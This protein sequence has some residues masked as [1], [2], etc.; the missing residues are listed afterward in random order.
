DAPGAPRVAVVS[1]RYWQRELGSARDPVGRELR[2]RGNTYTIVGVAAARFTGMVPVL[3][4][5]LWIPAANAQDVEPIGIHD[6]VPS[7]TG[8]TRLTKRGDRWMFLR[9]RLKP[10]KTADEARANLELV[11]S[12]LASE[13]P[14]TNGNRKISVPA[15]NDVHFHPSA[16]AT[17]FAVTGGVVVVVG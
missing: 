17:L 5:E 4:P 1:H 13:Y 15:T 2:I 11:M 6:S 14:V 16:D 7:P 12:R 8:T 3:A 10:G 9:G